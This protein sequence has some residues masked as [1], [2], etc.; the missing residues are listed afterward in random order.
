MSLVS[1]TGVAM[2]YV[3]GPVPSWRLG[4]SLG[5][6]L[7]PAKTCNWNCVYCQ[8]GRTRPVVNERR[9]FVPAAVVVSE[10]RSALESLDE[11]VVE[12]ITI[13]GSGEPLLHSQVGWII[14]SIKRLTPIP[15]AVI[16]NGS[17]LCRSEVRQELLAADAVLPTL[18]AGTADLFRRLNRPHP[19]I[20]LDR[21]TEGLAAFREAYTGRLLV[22]VMLIHGLNVGEPD[23]AAIA[24]RLAG[25][26]PDEIHVNAPKRCPAEPSVRAPDPGLVL[27]AVS[28]FESIALVRRAGQT[29][30]AFRIDPCEPIVDAVESIVTRHPMTEAELTRALAT[31][32]P[33]RASAAMLELERSDRLRVVVWDG[34]WYWVSTTAYFPEEADTARRS[35]RLSKGIPLP[36]LDFDGCTT[37]DN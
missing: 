3:Y 17:L 14:D 35:A 2:R 32:V 26:R 34:T 23:T 10:V 28:T 18:D 6:D 27:S 13:L 21:H 24:S 1:R 33:E 9:E 29:G 37:D 25:I 15:V 5:V 16:T 7:V 11:G 31:S 36:A 30:G 19:D 8:L 12:W 22:E 4:R 20:T